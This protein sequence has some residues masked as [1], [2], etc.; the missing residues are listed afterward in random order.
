MEKSIY[1]RIVDE[2]GTDVQ[3]DIWIEECAELI[4]ALT[5]FK[6]CGKT[7]N[8]YEEIADVEICIEEMKTVF[9]EL[10]LIKGFKE[11]K[12]A[13]MEAILKNHNKGA[14]HAQS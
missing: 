2:F 6:R 5:K 4:Q 12:L 10:D 9:K 3:I 13:R 1:E 11:I 8:V 7:D 14:E